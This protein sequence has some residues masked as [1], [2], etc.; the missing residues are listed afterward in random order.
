MFVSI[1]SFFTFC[2]VVVFRKVGRVRPSR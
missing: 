1:A 2:G